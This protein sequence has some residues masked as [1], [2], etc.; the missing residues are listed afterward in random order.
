[1]AK[2]WRTAS[3][4]QASGGNCVEVCLNEQVEV[5][6]SK[7]PAVGSLAVSR[8]DWAVLKESITS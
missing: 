1:M 5:R 3:R 2:K 8:T 7:A 6:D 4:S